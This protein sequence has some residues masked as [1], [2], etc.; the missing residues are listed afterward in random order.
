MAEVVA[1]VP[2]EDSVAWD[3]SPGKTLVAN[4][5]FHYTTLIS[6]FRLELDFRVLFGLK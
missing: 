5:D 6:F 3:L 1:R 2:A 4:L